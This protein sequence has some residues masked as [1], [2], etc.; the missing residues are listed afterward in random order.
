MGR[1]EVGSRHDL[2]EGH[3]TAV[4]VDSR[5][6]RKAIVQPG[7]RKR[8]ELGTPVR[9]RADADLSGRT[10]RKCLD[11]SVGKAALGFDQAS[12]REQHRAMGRQCHPARPPVEQRNAELLLELAHTLGQ[13]GPGSPRARVPQR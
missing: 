13:C 8:H 7:N 3:P 4:Q 12:V 1:A 5:L 10:L 11:L 9:S 6:L 2:D